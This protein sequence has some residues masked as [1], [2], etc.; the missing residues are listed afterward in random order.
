M[1]EIKKINF[2]SELIKLIL[3]TLLTFEI[4]KKF[5]ILKKIDL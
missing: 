4:L 1:K 5:A 2:R 3:K